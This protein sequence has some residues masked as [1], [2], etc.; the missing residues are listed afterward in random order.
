M[1]PNG[2][3]F[4]RE[5]RN[6]CVVTRVDKTRA[7]ALIRKHYLKKWPGVNVL[8][9]GLQKHEDLLGVI[10]FSLPPRETNKRYGGETWELSRLWID[11]SVPKNAETY[12][13]GRAIRYIKNNFPKVKNLVSYADPSFGHTGT[14]YRASNWQED[15]RTDQERK[16]PRFDYAD[17]NTGKKYARRA[18]VPFGT[19][20]VR[21]PRVSKF[22]YIYPLQG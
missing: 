2:V 19:K 10:V 16:T 11:D 8:V 12:L 17:A 4:D 1:K 13:I 22:R 9:L 14:I 21:V 5:W 7:D 18:H 3:V 6:V 20:I 15:G